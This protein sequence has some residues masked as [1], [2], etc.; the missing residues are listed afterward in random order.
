VLFLPHT[1]YPSEDWLDLNV[2]SPDLVVLHQCFIGATT[3]DNFTIKSGADSKLFDKA[4]LVLGG[5]IHTG[6]KV[7][8]VQYTGAP[9]RFNYG[10]TY[11]GRVA[12]LKDGEL[13]FVPTEMPV[14]QLVTC[15]TVAELKKAKSEPGLVKTVLNASI[16]VVEE[17]KS[18]GLVADET[19]IVHEK[20]VLEL[21]S[22][23]DDDL[24]KWG[25]FCVSMNSEEL[26]E[27][28]EPL[29]NNG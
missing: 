2:E 5:D 11:E 20:E 1:S 25:V 3:S 15:S 27:A 26:Y 10:D 13:S 29:F 8:N 9:T 4:K 28:G 12:I 21:V 23:E 14:K 17:A 7:G 22:D 19:K 16:E 6:C 24:A 18:F